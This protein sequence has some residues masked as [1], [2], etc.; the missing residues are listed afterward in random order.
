MSASLKSTNLDSTD[1]WE[2]ILAIEAMLCHESCVC[3]NQDLQTKQISTEQPKKHGPIYGSKLGVILVVGPDVRITLKAFYDNQDVSTI[4]SQKIARPATDLNQSKIDDYVREF[5]NRLAG[6]TKRILADSA[7]LAGISLPIVTRGF[8]EVFHTQNKA[9]LEKTNIWS[10][11][12]DSA[13]TLT[14][15]SSIVAVNQQ[16]LN[17]FRF[18]PSSKETADDMEFL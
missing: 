5:L 6:A 14:F 18:T 1:C 13:A 12:S 4:L 8:D 9:G 10:L 7:I 2:G 11:E 16:N 3:L 15:S 17:Q